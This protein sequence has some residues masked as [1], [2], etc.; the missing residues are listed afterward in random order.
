MCG[1]FFDFNGV[2]GYAA[3]VAGSVQVFGSAL[4][5][6]R[7]R[8]RRLAV[9]VVSSKPSADSLL[10]LVISKLG[11]V[12][13]FAAA[14]EISLNVVTAEQAPFVD[15]LCALCRVLLVCRSATIVVFVFLKK[16]HRTLVDALV[17]R[18][19]AACEQHWGHAASL[20][21]LFSL[22]RRAVY[23]LVGAVALHVH[24]VD[25]TLAVVALLALTSAVVVLA[26]AG[27]VAAGVRSSE[28]PTPST[29]LTLRCGDAL[30]ERHLL[31]LQ[32]AIAK[33][34]GL[35]CL[36]CH[37]RS[38]RAG[39]WTYA[40]ALDCSV[41]DRRLAPLLGQLLR[42]V[43]RLGDD[44]TNDGRVPIVSLALHDAAT[45]PL[46]AD[47]DVDA[48]AQQRPEAAERWR[49]ATAQ[50][51]S[52]QQATLA[53]H[54]AV[55]ESLCS[56]LGNLHETLAKL[57]KSLPAPAPPQQND[58]CAE[59]PGE[60]SASASSLLP[61]PQLNLDPRIFVAP[62]TAVADRR[63]RR[64]EFRHRQFLLEQQAKK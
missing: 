38:A 62:P 46:T 24:G 11:V 41:D 14:L 59:P 55:M 5:T 40:F 45:A 16:R 32:A 35:R 47:V 18:M 25:A 48:P 63:V 54:A 27:L 28:P 34:S 6:R 57:D 4:F 3:R 8:R 21:S 39:R 64:M 19:A 49:D 17:E 22:L 20:D 53:Q 50:L 36:S 31:R 58:E 29:V 2:S 33:D 1:S 9:D 15:F 30:S 44:S 61:A 37:C 43:V 51:A 23:C 52:L 10:H 13:R 60:K 42:A 12:A 7:R 26:A 56:V